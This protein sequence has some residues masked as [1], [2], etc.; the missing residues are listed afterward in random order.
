MPTPLR[1]VPDHV[2]R[3]ALD[4]AR[5][6]SETAA[7]LYIGEVMKVGR[8]QR[9]E[10]YRTQ[11][12]SHDKRPP[13]DTDGV[14]GTTEYEPGDFAV[15][16]ETNTV[17]TMDEVIT[18]CKVDSAEW[19]PRGFSVTRRKTGFGWN[20]RFAKKAK[21]VDTRAMLDTFI[22]QAAQ[23]AP[24]VFKLP[25]PKLKDGRL[26]EISAM[27]C[28][29]SKLCWNQETRGPDYDLKIAASDYREAVYGLAG[30]A[31]ANGVTRIL[32]PIGNDVLN[33]DNLNGTTT[34]GT[35]QATSE[36]GRWQKAY[37][38]VCSLLTEVIETLAAQFAVDI[39]IV[40]GNHDKE[41]CYYV[42]EYLRAWFRNHKGV[43][44]DNAPAQRK[45]YTFG[46]VLLGFT[47]GNEEKHSKLPLLM[48]S[49]A[50]ESW[51]KTTVREIHVGHLHQERVTEDM[52][53]KVRVIS[54]MVPQDEWATSKGY[55][56]NIR[57]AE[58][59]LYDAEDGLLANYYHNV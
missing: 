38:T 18:L 22:E 13:S 28:H 23:H 29:F 14:V 42:G 40:S 52:G 36:D 21:P 16:V 10:L 55:V 26:L 59:F 4:I 51:S 44:I 19:E 43:S 27:D 24:K 56:G 32:M 47:H 41:R 45:Y 2:K 37:T 57:L 5:K 31:K 15:E 11:V 46:T 58:A 48:A 7:R 12:K 39:I 54:A 30:Y 3:R 53:V 6:D 9:D 49:E 34:A 33:S 25:T 17:K 8:A 50:K 20:A 35:P 1:I